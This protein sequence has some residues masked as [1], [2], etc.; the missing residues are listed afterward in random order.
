LQREQYQN[1]GQRFDSNSLDEFIKSYQGN[2]LEFDKDSNYSPDVQRIIKMLK[3][4]S[5]G[6][7]DENGAMFNDAKMLIPGFVQLLQNQKPLG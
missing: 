5:E 2:P 1:T 6:K 4:S 7:M 3:L